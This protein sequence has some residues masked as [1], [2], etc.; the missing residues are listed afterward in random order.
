MSLLKWISGFL[1]SAVTML[2]CLIPMSARSAN[3][4]VNRDKFIWE[5][6]ELEYLQALASD[7]EE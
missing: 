7:D 1:Y 4:C 3:I 6:D 5:I 2:I